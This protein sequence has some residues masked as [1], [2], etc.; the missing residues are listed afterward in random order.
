MDISVRVYI[1]VWFLLREKCD[2]MMMFKS[3][4]VSVGYNAD[5]A[6]VFKLRKAGPND[7]KLSQVNFL[8]SNSAICFL[9]PQA[10]KQ[11][12]CSEL[13]PDPSYNLGIYR[14]S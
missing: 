9:P 10:R 3:C 8:D 1:Y 12:S 11:T 6:S 7:G 5:N 4:N 14:V 2:I 13:D